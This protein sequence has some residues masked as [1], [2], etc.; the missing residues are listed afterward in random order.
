MPRLERDPTQRE[1]AYLEALANGETRPAISG[2]AGHMCR[3]LGWCEALFAASDGAEMPS[4]ALPPGLD[5]FAVVR[6]GYRAIGFVLTAKG[7][8][9]L[10]L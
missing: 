1:R 5:A 9:V 6:A 7:R 2:Q 4:S 8:R 3:R 10:G